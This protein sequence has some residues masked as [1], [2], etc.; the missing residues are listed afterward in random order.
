MNCLSVNDFNTL[1]RKASGSRFVFSSENQP[2][3]TCG[4][5]T[6]FKIVFNSFKVLFEPDTIMFEDSNNNKLF[7]RNVKNIEEDTEEYYIG[8]VF[9][10]VCENALTHNEYRY[11][12]IAQ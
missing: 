1:Y 7:L 8:K 2:A 6:V 4:I 3:D 10:V 11:T 12:F 9:T 5:S